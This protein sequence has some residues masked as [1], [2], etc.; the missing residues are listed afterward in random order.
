MTCYRNHV[1][2]FQVPTASRV[3][4]FLGLCQST[5]P[6]ILE[7]LLHIRAL[8][9]DL[10]NAIAPLGPHA[11]YKIKVT[12]SQEAI[13]YLQWQID[14]AHLNNGRDIIPP[15][16]NTMIFCN[17]SKIGWGIHLDSI[18]IWGR[19]LTHSVRDAHLCARSPPPPFDEM[20]IYAHRNRHDSTPRCAFECIFLL[21]NLNENR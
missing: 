20:K 9:M 15:P 3:A 19:W 7:T 21:V 10:I 4:S 6:T 2:S 13:N 14:S 17:A 8:Q 16:V 18:L 12:L 1:P 5:M 11:Y